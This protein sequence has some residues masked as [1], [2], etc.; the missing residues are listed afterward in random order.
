MPLVPCGSTPPGVHGSST[1]CSQ[2]VFVG[3]THAFF[4]AHDLAALHMA[5]TKQTARKSTGGK[6]PRR[7]LAT[8]ASREL[9]TFL[10]SQQSVGT[11][12]AASRDGRTRQSFLNHE[13]VL[14][15]FA[16]TTKPTDEKFEA[17]LGLSVVANPQT[18]LDE[19]WLGVQ[20]ASK[21]DGEGMARHG[22]APISL[23]MVLDISGSM[24]MRLDG[25]SEAEGAPPMSKLDVA[26]RCVEEILGQLTP[27]DVVGVMLFNHSTTMLHAPAKCTGATR[28][29]IVRKLQGV[30]PGGGTCLREGFEAGMAALEG[31]PGVAATPLRRTYFL[32][33]MLSSQADEAAVLDQAAR[34]AAHASLPLHTTVVGVGVDLSVG[35]VERLSATPG[36]KYS[37][38]FAAAEFGSRVAAEFAHDVSPIG[39][40]IRLTLGGGWAIERACGSAE[41]N[42]LAPGA[43][44][45][46]I[47]SE[48]AT[49]L[50]AHGEVAGGIILL[51]LRAPPAAAPAASAVQ[52]G[53]SLRSAG[54]QPASNGAVVPCTVQWHD[55]GGAHQCELGAALPAAAA[56]AAAASAAGSSSAARV[57]THS[58]VAMRKALALTRFVDLQRE[59]CDHEDETDL[60]GRL[61][62]LHEC[63]A[64]RASWLDEMGA[65]G[66]ETLHEDGSNASFLQTLDQIIAF[67]DRETK[68]Q[69]ARETPTTEPRRSKRAQ[70]AAG[71][72]ASPAT[73]RRASAT[74][75]PPEFLC[76]ILREVMK[77]PVVTADGQTYERGAIEQWL[78]DHNTAPL[79]GQALAHKHLTP[80]VL[81]RGMI[82]AHMHA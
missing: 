59:F 16:Y 25:D 66:D 30:K 26:K 3:S 78:R 7:Q 52:S 22:R 43:T 82:R 46:E 21:Y 8:T 18:G 4:A 41:L 29:A 6:A 31:A 72:S 35:T 77:D 40:G 55:V 28:D 80:N 47:S 62:R 70:P 74:S 81:L 39:F 37:S 57:G 79:T 69:R 67:E 13:N 53:R 51:Q 5:R 76:P 44:A 32:T 27:A 49:Q 2:I 60:E 38:V 17:Q 73:K 50:D 19:H 12:V 11:S 9:R 68:A 45:I 71:P 48:F 56:A 1:G 20:F 54:Q 15:S 24:S 65:C 61:R 42:G 58:S 34:R 63:R 33:D 10:T 64:F 14:S 23:M 36:C 75:E